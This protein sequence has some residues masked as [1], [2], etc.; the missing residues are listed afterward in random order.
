[1]SIFNYVRGEK[2]LIFT[3]ITNPEGKPY[4]LS[5]FKAVYMHISNNDRSFLVKGRTSTNSKD[6]VIYFYIGP[7]IT[8]DPASYVARLLFQDFKDNLAVFSDTTRAEF[9]I[10]VI[11][12]SNF[13]L[14][15][16][17]ADIEKMEG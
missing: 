6:G 4:P 13:S 7:E 2:R 11:E 1:M 15:E 8:K 16:I 12:K 10:N 5:I 3:R 17:K 9:H 14:D